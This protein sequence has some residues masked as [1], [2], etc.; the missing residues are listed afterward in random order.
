MVVTLVNVVFVS[1]YENR[2]SQAL[3]RVW[4]IVCLS[5]D[6]EE[7]WKVFSQLALIPLRQKK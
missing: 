6:Q 3:F 1:V 7:A 4:A 5:L 2:V